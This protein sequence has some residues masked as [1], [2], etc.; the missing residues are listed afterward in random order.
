MMYLFINENQVEPYNGEN[1]KRYIGNRL[2][3]II[4]NPTDE[5]LLEFGYKYLDESAEMPTEREGYYIEA[6]YEDGDKIKKL[7][8]E[9]EIPE[10]VVEEM[11]ES[12]E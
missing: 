7:Y 10:E 11:P 4:S 8:R 6:Y 1:L 12:E 5:H 2:V 3:K 9:V